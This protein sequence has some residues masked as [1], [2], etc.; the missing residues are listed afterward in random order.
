MKFE[1]NIKNIEGF[2]RKKDAERLVDYYWLHYHN[3]DVEIPSDTV[4]VEAEIAVAERVYEFVKRYIETT[5]PPTEPTV[6]SEEKSERE[7]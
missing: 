7:A 4:G 6:V 1:T 3:K 5:E 2:A